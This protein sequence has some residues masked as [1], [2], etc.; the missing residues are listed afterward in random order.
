MDIRKALVDWE[1]EIRRDERQKMLAR[2]GGKGNAAG[3]KVKKRTAKR[4][5]PIT[6]PAPGCKNPASRAPRFS[7][8]CDTHKTAAP[9]QRKKWLENWKAKAKSEN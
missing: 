9:A 8:L 6:C 1:Q 2:L 3:K 4:N 5:L 7:F